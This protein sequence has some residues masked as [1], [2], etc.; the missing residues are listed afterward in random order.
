M[1]E[2]HK[3]LKTLLN[4]ALDLKNVNHEKLAEL[5]GVPE[6]FLWAIQNVEVE[7]LPPA[8][9]IRG[10]IQKISE[11]LHLNHDELWELYKKELE[12]KTSGVYDTLPV[13]RFAIRHLTRK[14]LFFIALGMAIDKSGLDDIFSSILGVNLAAQPYFVVLLTIAL[15]GIFM[16]SFI[17]NTAASSVLIPITTSLAALLGLNM[18]NFV[19]ASAFGVSLDFIFPMGTPPSALAYSTKYVKIKDM[20]KSGLVIS[21]IGAVILVLFAYLTWGFK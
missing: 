14:T 18:T 12:H 11:A 9:Y 16:T 1:P 2:Y 20:I 19:V 6:R 13:N 21:I 15:V 10:Y 4:E 5:T 7:K 8:P 17:S 3:D